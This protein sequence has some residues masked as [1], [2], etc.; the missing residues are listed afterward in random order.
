MSD[1]RLLVPVATSSTV[2]QTVEYAVRTA[3]DGEGDGY[4]RFVYVHS[5]EVSDDRLD[6]QR[7]SDVETISELLDR[8]TVWAEEDAGDHAGELTV[9]TDQIGANRYLFSPSDVGAALAETAAENDI[10]RVVLDPEYDPGVGSPLL[11]P[12]EVELTRLTEIPVEEAPVQRQVRRR[13]LVLRSS[14]LQAGTLVFVSFVFYQILGGTFDAFDLVTGAVSAT[15]VGVSLA[16]ITFNH[17]PSIAWLGRLLRMVIY[18]PYLFVEIIKANVQVAAVILDPRLP[19]DPRLTQVN[20]AVWGSVPVTTLAN[21]ITLTPGT[22]TVRVEGRT[23]TVH[24]LVAGPREGLFDGGL[25]R[26]VRFVF[27]G[28][29][30]MNMPTPRE[31]GDTEVLQQP[32]D[33]DTPT[34]EAVEA[35]G[36]DQQ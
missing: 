30:A 32:E 31:R 5:P 33:A 12:L 3:L 24:T 20:A 14:P 16:R 11:R 1:N 6:D 35:D 10:G 2:R 21:S 36:G 29:S 15:I 25:E 28:R 22:L 18:V 13:P 34:E 8:I 27:Y 7:E 4:V 17:D 19:I 23:L 26:A 9:E